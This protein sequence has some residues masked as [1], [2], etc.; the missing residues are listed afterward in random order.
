MGRLP[1]STRVVLVSLL[2]A[3]G[4]VVVLTAWALTPRHRITREN[5]R[6]IDFAM[7]Q[8]D[9]EELLGVPAGD[10]GRGVNVAHTVDESTHSQKELLGETYSEWYADEVGIITAADATGKVGF[11]CLVSVL[12][13]PEPTLLER[14][15]HWLRL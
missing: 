9:V 13:A 4:S 3:C 11:K 7:T 14:I 2:L 12:R 10:Y 1:W 8:R 6:K 5:Y 15:R